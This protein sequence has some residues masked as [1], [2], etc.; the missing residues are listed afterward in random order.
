MY[1]FIIGTNYR[2]TEV[3]GQDKTGVC[4][5]DISSESAV[6]SQRAGLRCIHPLQ[7]VISQRCDKCLYRGWKTQLE[8]T[9][10]TVISSS[11]LSACNLGGTVVSVPPIEAWTLNTL[12]C[13]FQVRHTR[14]VLYDQCMWYK[15]IKL[16]NHTQVSFYWK[17]YLYF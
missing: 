6:T 7:N 2:N 13:F 11:F 4:R 15:I 12:H 9:C 8:N 10:R 17:Y 3:Q 16:I 14:R 5:K 1:L